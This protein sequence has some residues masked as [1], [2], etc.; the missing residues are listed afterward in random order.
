MIPQREIVDKTAKETALFLGRR[1]RKL[2]TEIGGVL[3]V[4]PFLMRALKDFHQI[5]DQTSLSEFML[6]W[7]LANGHATGFG[8]M[9]DEKVLPQV[10]GTKRLDSSC[11]DEAPYNREIFDDIDHIVTRR[12]GDYLL[13]LKA[14][15]WT[16]QLGQAMGLYRHFLALGKE[17]LQS[18]GIVVGVFYGHKGLLRDK[19][20]IV[21][22]EN[23]RH[24]SEMEKLP[25][26]EVKAGE[27]FWT[28]LNDDTSLTQDWL[29]EGIA[30]G[31]DD[32]LAGSPDA[33]IVIGGAPQRLVEELRAKYGLPNDGSIDWALLLHAVN[34][35]KGDEI[36]SEAIEAAPPAAEEE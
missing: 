16:I 1:L 30:K 3:N 2:R 25:Y 36:G 21:K 10:F 12:D 26:V 15:A 35:D 28:W 34:D 24:Q 8:K 29:M 7:H 27:K 18:K 19:Y 31:A 9:I 32:F 6:T 13:P 4:N 5:K 17:K 22:G 11:R 20:R 23:E 33:S 14:G